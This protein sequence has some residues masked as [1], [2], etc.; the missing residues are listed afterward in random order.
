MGQLGKLIRTKL[1]RTK[2]V[3]GTVVLL[4]SLFLVTQL[5]ARDR[6]ELNNG[7]VIAA[8]WQEYSG[9]YAAYLYQSFNGAS[10]QLPRQIAA[11]PAGKKPAIITD[12]DDTLIP[13]THYFASLVDTD[14]TNSA[15]PPRRQPAKALPGAV[16]FL[17]QAN[18]LGVEIFYVSRRSN[19]TKAVTIKALQQLGY[20]VLS[21][22]HVLLQ[23]PALPPGKQD[24]RQSIIDKGYHPVMLLGDQLEDLHD[25]NSDRQQ[26]VDH[27]RN[28][29]GRQWFILPNSVYGLWAEDIV[30]DEQNTKATTYPVAPAKQ[31]QQHIAT[32]ELWM[33]QSADFAATTLQ[34]YNLASRAL[35]TPENSQAENRAVV[36]DIDG[37]LINYP[38]IHIDPP[39]CR[40]LPNS[41]EKMKSYERQ[42]GV[43]AIPGAKAFLDRAVALGYKIFYLTAREQSSGRAGFPGDIEELT[44]QQLNSYG[45]PNVT[46]VTLLNRAKYCPARRKSCGK[47]YQRQAI[48][49]G[50]VD[51][52]RYDIRL[53]VGDLLDDFDLKER[54]LSPFDRSSV[55]TTRDDYGRK[56]FV[57]PNPLNKTWMWHHYS[58][59]ARQDICQMSD[60]ERSEIR[61]KL[62]R[63]A[64][65][66]N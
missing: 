50:K 62:V 36:V 43:S 11:V 35:A 66:R 59:F 34:A 65:I 61:K 27:Y 31:Y 57:I 49:S 15:E 5:L 64:A 60:R 26:W 38:P 52:K 23:E 56:Y 47:E 21:E 7:V 6:K 25:V 39:F 18:A 55:E 3:N 24:K 58:R 14:G 30:A 44:L 1:I 37:T 13:A 28:H 9:E 10:D 20:P 22:Q 53:Y 45:F 42:L 29:F 51:G 16:A 8:N 41:E 32:A 63:E 33:S 40:T 2:L 4:L 12:I 54:G 19:K 48:A 17:Q 46:S